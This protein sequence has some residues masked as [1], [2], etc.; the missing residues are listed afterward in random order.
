MSKT[1]RQEQRRRDERQLRQKRQ[2]EMVI[3]THKTPKMIP[4]E[5]GK[6]Y[7][8]GDP[9]YKDLELEFLR[10]K[11]VIKAEQIY[12]RKPTDMEIYDLYI[13]M[14]SQM[15]PAEAGA[16][17]EKLRDELGLEGGADLRGAELLD[18]LFQRMAGAVVE[19]ERKPG[20]WT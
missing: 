1:S 3:R 10:V 19:A 13:G 18:Y 9:E 16:A 15:M 5:D 12:G 17:L 14:G 20:S 2:V 7:R 6:E 11:A 8:T 4:D